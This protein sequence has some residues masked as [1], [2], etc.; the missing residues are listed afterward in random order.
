MSDLDL[1]CAWQQHQDRSPPMPS[2]ITAPSA[3]AIRPFPGMR[4]LCGG[5]VV[6]ELC[7]T[8]QP[9]KSLNANKLKPGKHLANRPCSTALSTANHAAAQGSKWESAL[10]LMRSMQTVLLLDL[11]LGCVEVQS[12]RRKAPHES[13]MRYRGQ[14][15]SFSDPACSPGPLT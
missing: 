11:S 9:P 7:S 13:L 10:S 14:D 5:S 2:A 4:V 8:I 1:A 6:L 12:D 15:R 3:P